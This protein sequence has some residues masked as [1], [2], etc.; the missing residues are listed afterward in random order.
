MTKGANAVITGRDT[1]LLDGR[2][3]RAVP[4][5]RGC[6]GCDGCAAMGYAKRRDIELCNALPPCAGHQRG[7]GPDIIWATRGAMTRKG[8]VSYPAAEPGHGAGRVTE[9]GEA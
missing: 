3:Y 9:G 8:G 4:A 5:R 6:D 7:G 1:C 2:E